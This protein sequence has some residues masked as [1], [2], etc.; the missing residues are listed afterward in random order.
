MTNN[1]LPNI[2]LSNYYMCNDRRVR[3]PEGARSTTAS[4]GHWPTTDRSLT[5]TNVTHINN[6][7]SAERTTPGDH[8]RYTYHQPHGSRGQPRNGDPARAGAD[9]SEDT[10]DHKRYTYHQP[11]GSRGQPR[12]GDPARA[13]A[14]GSEAKRRAVSVTRGHFSKLK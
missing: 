5:I 8:K 6:R 12:S 14:D 10:G 13:G 1:Y 9:G 4:G 7:Q 11:H 2:Q 3:H